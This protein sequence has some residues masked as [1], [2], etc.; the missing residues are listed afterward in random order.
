[1][2]RVVLALALLLAA[3]TP[4]ELDSQYVL[5]RYAVAIESV[6]VPKA[7]IFTYTVSQAG[8]GNIDQRHVIY[9]NGSQVRDET[10]AVDGV[11]LVHKVV[12]FARRE[13]RYDVARIAPRA[14]SYEL[15]FLRS[16]KDGHHIDYEY[17]AAPLLHG[18]DAAVDRVTI[19]GI[20]YLPKDVRFK[21]GAENA[22]GAAHVQ[23]A[24][25]G[26]YWMPV[27]AEVTAV[28][29]GKPARERIVWSDYRFPDSLPPSTFEPPR[30]L[31]RSTLP[32]M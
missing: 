25:F 7:V 10:L 30:P 6:P 22:Q 1:M 20:K 5:Q 8:P 16:I 11:A 3:A 32:P 13:D 23:Y 9:R 29:K 12:T 14:A 15:L 19:D 31:P 2:K 21:T 26:K 17:D 18:A 4:A 24:Q 28:V 27:L